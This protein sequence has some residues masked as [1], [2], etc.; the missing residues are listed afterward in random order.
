MKA[1]AW[2]H[3]ASSTVT[4]RPLAVAKQVAWSWKCTARRRLERC[5]A[6]S[7]LAASTYC[8][9]LPAGCADSGMAAG[10]GEPR[11]AAGRKCGSG[12]ASGG[13]HGVVR[14]A[15]RR[16]SGS[17][18]ARLRAPG[19]ERRGRPARPSRTPRRPRRS[20]AS[21][22]RSRR[23]PPTPLPRAVPCV[24]AAAC[25]FATASPCLG[26]AEGAGCL[27]GT[28][29]PSRGG[30]ACSWLFYNRSINKVTCGGTFFL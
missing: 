25:R 1:L 16:A 26:P 9:A 10:R 4:R 5:R 18:R 20:T 3:L 30:E 21:R 7:R 23:Y 22:R 15:W 27:G 11:A 19:N 28:R 14:A 6:L 29:L 13:A 17:V 8:S 12:S 2:M 24:P